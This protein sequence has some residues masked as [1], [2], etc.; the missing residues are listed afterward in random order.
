M[1]GRWFAAILT[2]LAL[3]ACRSPAPSPEMA[4]ESKLEGSGN[5][6]EVSVTRVV[7]PD[8]KEVLEA[9]T[10]VQGCTVILAQNV[11][12]KSYRLVK[13]VVGTESIDWQLE[14]GYSPSYADVEELVMAEP[15]SLPQLKDCRD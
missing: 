7:T 4:F 15:P 13:L 5:F 3:V 10:T 14:L 2:G 11:G 12:W 1:V 8:D 6:K 9:K